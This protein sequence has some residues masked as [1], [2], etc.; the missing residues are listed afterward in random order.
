MIDF[1]FIAGFLTVLFI[2]ALFVLLA[3]LPL[4]IWL[5]LVVGLLIYYGVF[6]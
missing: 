6:K 5:V 4:W 3:Q 1:S 2:A